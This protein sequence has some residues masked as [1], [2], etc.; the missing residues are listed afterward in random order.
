MAEK[1]PERPAHSATRRSS[2]FE[3]DDPVSAAL[4]KAMTRRSQKEKEKA[5][6]PPQLSYMYP[7]S[8]SASFELP[9]KPSRS[10]HHHASGILPLETLERKSSPF[11]AGLRGG[12]HAS[13]DLSASPAAEDR[14][15]HLA[16]SSSS[17]T[18]EHLLEKVAPKPRLTASQSYSASNVMNLAQREQRK[19][20]FFGSFD[21]VLPPSTNSSPDAD[22]M[23]LYS[24]S[25]PGQRWLSYAKS[26]KP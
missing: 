4:R 19:A 10:M 18:Q 5:E 9:S 12:P 11:G 25:E 21:G 17:P 26:N 8:K 7:T 6:N 20:R 16:Q 14:S 2:Y 22:N 1:E 15:S 24:I 3:N 13:F 23:D